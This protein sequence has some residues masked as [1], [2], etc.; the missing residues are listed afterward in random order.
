MRNR[1]LNLSALAITVTCLH[2]ANGLSFC[3]TPLPKSSMLHMSAVNKVTLERSREEI[4][5]DLSHGRVLENGP[6]VDFGSMKNASSKAEL[7][8]AQA[9]VDYLDLAAIDTCG[10]DVKIEFTTP[11]EG[12]D[13]K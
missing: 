10:R 12:I 8:L 11:H 2:Q 4:E 7:A 3:L 9:R 1:R 6:V 13:V 5:V